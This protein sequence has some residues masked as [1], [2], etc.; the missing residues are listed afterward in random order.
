MER[1]EATWSSRA[2]WLVTRPVRALDFL[3]RYPL[4]PAVVLVALVITGIVARVVAPYNPIIGN[5]WERATPPM[6]QA[7]GS[8]KHILG[9][10]HVGRDV[11]SRLLYGAQVSLMV[12]G[13]SVS[14]GFVVGSTLGVI[15]G[16]FGG[17]IDEIITRFV[18]MWMATPFL[19]VALIVALVL[20]Q[21]LVILLT[22]LA[23]LAW[24]GF[25]RVVRGHALTFKDSDYIS[26][27]K[28]A[29]AS[30]WRILRVHVVPGIINT[31]VINATLNI[32]TLIM[33]EATLSFLGVGIPP[34][35]PSWGG[36][37]SDG[38]NYLVDAWWQSF[39][40]GLCIFLTVLSLQFLGDWLRDYLDPRLRQLI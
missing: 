36:M 30:T 2:L 10:D 16:W 1:V 6:W 18:D 39:F 23:I 4:L 29:G 13:I 32:G 17:I 14:A 26:L 25:V 34:P 31:A 11:L 21:S 28:V 38:R 12:A 15:A 20:G 22:L 37:V 7:G 33:M 5:M 19:L 9:T 24:V 40:P 3:R 8:A 27:A 35:T